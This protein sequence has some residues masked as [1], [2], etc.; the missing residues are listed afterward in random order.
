MIIFLAGQMLPGDPGRADPRAPGGPAAVEKLDHQL[1]VDRPI[2]TQYK[3]WIGGLLHGDIG[4]S[5]TYQQP[6]R[7]V[8][9]EAL[10]NS[11]KLAAWRS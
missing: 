10:V 7:A 3:D 9:H 11:L 4:T 2:V 8:P 6:D 1:G 5:Y